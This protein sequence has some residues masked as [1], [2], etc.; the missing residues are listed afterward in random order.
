MK[1]KVGD[2]VSLKSGAPFIFDGIHILN[3][4]HH[5]KIREINEEDGHIWL[6]Y[7]LGWIVEDKLVFSKFHVKRKDAT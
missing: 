7:R 1:F 3:P 5:L 4:V 6:E 2:I